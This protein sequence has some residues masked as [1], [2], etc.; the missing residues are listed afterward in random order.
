VRQGLKALPSN[1][2]PRVNEKLPQTVVSSCRRPGATPTVD[3]G[4]LA[5]Q[6]PVFDPESRTANPRTAIFKCRVS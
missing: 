4:A 6:S 1:D 3:V 2:L 5:S